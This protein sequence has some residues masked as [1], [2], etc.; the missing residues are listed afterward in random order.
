M[1]SARFSLRY[2]R[3]LVCVMYGISFVLCAG[4]GLCHMQFAATNLF[5]SLRA[6]LATLGRERP[7]NGPREGPLLGTREGPLLGNNLAPPSLRWQTRSSHMLE[8]TNNTRYGLPGIRL[9]RGREGLPLTQSLRAFPWAWLSAEE[10]HGHLLG[11][12]RFGV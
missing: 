3:S 8:Q 11:C 1:L 5:A 9:K 10:T 6:C 7:N 4:F 2:V 12:S